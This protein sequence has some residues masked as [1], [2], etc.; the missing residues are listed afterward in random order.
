MQLNKTWTR[1]EFFKK[2]ALLKLSNESRGRVPLGNA[3]LL[4]DRNYYDRIT[5]YF[6]V[7]RS[8]SCFPYFSRNGETEVFPMLQEHRVWDEPYLRNGIKF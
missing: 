4:L 2:L 3:K 5:V 1:A 8:F 6:Q 7:S